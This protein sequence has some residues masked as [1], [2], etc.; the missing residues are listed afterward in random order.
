[1]EKQHRT[2]AHDDS[3]QDHKQSQSHSQPIVK[4]PELKQLQVD[5]ALFVQ[6]LGLN[7]DQMGLLIEIRGGFLGELGIALSGLSG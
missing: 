2:H 6:V 1:M 3:D 7:L 5:G 4:A